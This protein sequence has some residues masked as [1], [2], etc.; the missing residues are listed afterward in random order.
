MSKVIHIKLNSLSID[1][2]I[3]IK[4]WKIGFEK[5]NFHV[6]MHS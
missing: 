1:K 2:A 5:A 3:N 6:F 4:T